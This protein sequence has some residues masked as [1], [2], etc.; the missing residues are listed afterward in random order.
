ATNGVRGVELAQLALDVA[1]ELLAVLTLEVAQ[2]LNVA[3]ELG[4]LLLELGALLVERCD[5]RA[6]GGL[7]FSDDPRRRCVA[8]RDECV[9]LLDALANVLLVQAACELQKVVRV[10]G[11]EAR[12]GGRSRV[13]GCGNHGGRSGYRS[14][15]LRLVPENGSLR[16]RLRRAALQLVDARLSGDESLA[17]FLVLL[18]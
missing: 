9:A 1:L 12:I 3:L 17:K 13:G 15:G 18:V 8:F 4:A 10:V 14:R 5:L 7:G 2:L 11:V 16:W 6:L